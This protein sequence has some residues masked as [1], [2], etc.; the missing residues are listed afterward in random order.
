METIDNPGPWPRSLK[1]GIIGGL[2]LIVV[3]YL[4][5]MNVD[6]SDVESLEETKK[7]LFHY[8]EYA[9]LAGIVIWSQLEHRKKDLG[10]F[11]SYGRAVG[12]AT[13][14]GMGT[15][16]CIAIFMYILY[17]IQHPE[18]QQMLID[19]VLS[20]GSE[21]SPENEEMTIK[22]MQITTS[23]PAMAFYGFFAQTFGGLVIG[24]ISGIFIQKTDPQ[25]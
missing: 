25:N 24:L 14:A 15:G 7:S 18:Y 2:V 9:V 8:L 3:N 4:A 17:G 10:G 11:M 6:W 20:Q 23:P 13:I 22:I 19:Y 16:I 5:V 21:V 12:V 1:W